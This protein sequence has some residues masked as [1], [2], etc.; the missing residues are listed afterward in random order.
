MSENLKWMEAIRAGEY[1]SYRSIVARYKNA[2]Y[3]VAYSVLGDYHLAEDAAQ[4]AFLQAFLRLSDIRDPQKLGSWLYSIS[5]RCSIRMKNKRKRL[6][7]E[8]DMSMYGDVSESAET[9]VLR[10]EAHARILQSIGELDENNRITTALYYMCDLSMKE[11]AD[12]LGVS[13]RAVESRLQRAKKQLRASL[14][15]L[16]EAAVRKPALGPSFD[17]RIMR[18]IPRLM[19]IPCVFVDVRDI[20]YAMAWYE[21]VLGIDFKAREPNC[22]VNIAFRETSQANPSQTPVLTFATPSVTEAYSALQ[23]RG[24]SV[25]RMSPDGRSFAF[26]DPFGNVLAFVQE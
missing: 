24:V 13:V 20:D 1:D 15:A 7:L 10:R 18:E 26:E 19:R 6:V 22:G 8:E 23:S 12:F 11:I 16:D 5:Y 17:D 4:E 9:A 2:V 14:P 21:S 25:S 3:S